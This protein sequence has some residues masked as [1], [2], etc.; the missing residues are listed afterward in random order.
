[1]ARPIYGP[2]VVHAAGRISE[3]WSA[4]LRDA[5]ASITAAIAAADSLG[6]GKGH[7]PIHHFHRFE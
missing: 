1:M 5:K 7:G 2:L 4:I 3:A 6:V